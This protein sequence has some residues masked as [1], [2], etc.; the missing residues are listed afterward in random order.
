[1]ETTVK[2]AKTTS[3]VLANMVLIIGI[4]TFIGG[5]IVFGVTSAQLNAQG[6]TVAEITEEDPGPLAGQTVNGPFQ[7]LAQ[8]N[9]IQHHTESITGGKTFAQLG[10]VATKNGQTYNKDVTAETSTDGEVHKAGDQL[11]EDDAK[12][13]AARS[14][15]QTASFLVASLFVSVLAFGV[16]TFIAAIGVVITLVGFSLRSLAKQLSALETAPEGA[17]V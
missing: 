9:A 13:F 2:A 1:M 10:N 12:T 14:T 15:A 16:A 3:K 17:A 6:I 11:S 5:I 8:I 7:A 4:I